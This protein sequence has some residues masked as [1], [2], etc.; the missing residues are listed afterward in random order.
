M[1][2]THGS[3]FCSLLD[4][5]LYTR[6]PTEHGSGWNFHEC[7]A[8]PYSVKP[9]A[10]DNGQTMNP[11]KLLELDAWQAAARLA[12]RELT[13]VD[14]VR[15]CLDRVGER[16]GE[17]HAF[18]QIDPDAAL[19]QARALDAGPI[20]GPL[21]GLPIGVK[22]LYDTVDFPTAYGSPVYAGQR[23]LAD[24]AAVALC[25]EAGA[26]VLGKTVT[27]E[28]AYFQPGPTRN[29]HNLAHTPGGSSSGSAAAVAD[30]MLPLALGTQTAGS[31]IRPAA[32]CGVVGYKPSHGRVT[33]AGVKS[34]SQTLDVVG[35]FGRSVR[36]VGLLGSVLTGDL[37]LTDWAEPTP[38]RIGLCQTPHWSQVDGDTQQAWAQA[39]ATLAPLAAH[40][41]DVVLPQ[42][43]DS[44]VPLQKEVM[45]FEMARALSHERVQHRNRLS[46]RLVALMDEGMAI[47]GTRH[48]A[49]LALTAA[50]RWRMDALFE[51]HDVLLI[52]SATGEAPAGI[53]ATGDPLF[54]RSWTL[55]GLPSVHLP[56]TRGSKGL[57]IG[58]QLVGRHGED[59]RLL[60]AAHWV[61]E[62]LLRQGA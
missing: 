31:L 6:I 2:V 50:W 4:G 32:Y 30:R 41:V 24:A 42:G 37:R 7:S 17:V 45:A 54:C 44:L 5:L 16:D 53:E 22:D 51:R 23:P 20:R 61:H 49:N 8:N 39:T 13:S 29:P 59:H 26:L 28:F 15:A 3:I 34:L 60:A 35:G 19:A 46:A 1:V 52:P 12:R 10:S 11:S 38:V 55:L 47:S 18:V 43:F 25:R 36:D 58:L 14:L 48:A 27:T 57:P 33:G 21:H 62:R 9:P 56:F 40:C